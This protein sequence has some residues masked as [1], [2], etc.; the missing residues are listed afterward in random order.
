MIFVEPKTTTIGLYD[1]F[2][3][4]ISCDANTL[5]D[6][7][8]GVLQWNSAT[9][10]NVGDLCYDDTTKRLFRSN[11]ENN[12]N[13]NP[14]EVATGVLGSQY[15]KNQGGYDSESD[16]GGWTDYGAINSHAFRDRYV[17]TQTE[18]TGNM[19]IELSF[20]KCNT[21]ALLNL[22]AT[23]VVVE[24]YDADDLLIY[25]KVL[26]MAVRDVS[27]WSDY[28]F[29]DLEYKTS[30]VLFD[31]PLV[32][33][34]RLKL[35]LVGDITKV[36]VAIVGKSKDSGVTLYGSSSGNISF[37][38]KDRDE[39]GETYLK[40]GEISKIMNLNVGVYTEQIPIIQKRL[41]SIDGKPV[42]FVGDTSEQSLENFLVFGFLRD[43][44][45]SVESC[46]FN[47]TYIE[48]EG[49]I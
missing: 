9:T 21:V 40:K 20:H 4:V 15:Y 26:N 2:C 35:T 42:L 16:I 45:I 3:D 12:L 7:H 25:S 17:S 8:S 43:F 32:L 41:E 36:G 29:E 37:S 14:V 47:T 19:T 22:E 46:K 28:F 27:S 6:I 23:S 39:T 5:K 31:L 13:R 33:N 30:M 10:Y 24:L 34:A 1:Y 48:I 11:M 44:D 49:L 38:K 18:K